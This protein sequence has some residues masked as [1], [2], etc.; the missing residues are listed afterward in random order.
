MQCDKCN[1]WVHI[2]C[3]K[4]HLQ[5]YKLLRKSSS[6]WYW[7]K[8]FEDIVP[9]REPNRNQSAMRNSLKQTQ[10]LNL[11]LLSLQKTTLHLARI[12]SIRSMKLWINLHLKS[13]IVKCGYEDN[14]KPVF[15]TKRFWAQKNT[16]KQK[17]TNKTKLNK[18]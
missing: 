5:T 15:P 12:P 4:I 11:S 7:I 8:C 17:W 18:Y 2:K 6:A 1:I 14:F 3:N 13:R 10:N 16:H 9:F